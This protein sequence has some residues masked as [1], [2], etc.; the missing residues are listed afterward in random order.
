M[1]DIQSIGD[2]AN[3]LNYPFPSNSLPGPS[4]PEIRDDVKV[5]AA[6]NENNCN[7]AK[8]I[9]CRIIRP[10]GSRRIHRYVFRYGYRTT[11]VKIKICPEK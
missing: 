10:G 3:K 4:E 9:E 2:F 11:V 8:A 7:A 6:N 1:V 5:V